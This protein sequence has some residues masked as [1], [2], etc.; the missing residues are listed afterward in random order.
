VGEYVAERVLEGGPV[1]PRFS[2]ATK[3]T[4]LKRDVT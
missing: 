1:E 4:E 3:G 2:L